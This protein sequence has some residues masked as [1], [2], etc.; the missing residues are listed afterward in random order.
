M[1]SIWKE[2]IRWSRLIAVITLV[3]AAIFSMISTAFLSGVGW[4]VGMFIV[5]VIIMTG[6]FFDMI[7]VAAT[8]ASEKPFHAMAAKKLPGAYHA[9]LVTRNADKVANFCADVV[10][11]ISGVVSGTAAS[12]VVLQL[13]FAA[14]AGDGSTLQFVLNVIFTAVVA[15]LTVSGKALGKTFA[16]TKST[17]I[18]YQ[19]GRIIYLSEEKLKIKIFKKKERKMKNT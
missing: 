5:F 7:G 19:V 1:N 2:S 12:A 10:G 17:A 15:A 4:A 3:L 9:M 11:D 14:G 8:A 16:I 18:I 13:T 6:V